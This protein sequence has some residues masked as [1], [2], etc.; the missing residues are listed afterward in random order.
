MSAVV[1][2]LDAYRQTTRPAPAVRRPPVA[3]PPRVRV[4]VRWDRVAGLL[5]ALVLAVV[6][7][8]GLLAGA[9]QADEPAGDPLTVV[10]GP[11]DTIWELA[12]A[13][14][15][16][17]VDTMTYAAAITAHNGVTATALRPGTVLELPVP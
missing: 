9:S 12:R 3:R 5:A 16:A 6:L 13:H 7:V 1:I 4:R 2:S 15:P 14:A 17:G 8:G 11:G 10:V